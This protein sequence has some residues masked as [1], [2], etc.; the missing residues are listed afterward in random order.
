MRESQIKPFIEVHRFDQCPSSWRELSNS[1][2]DEDWIVVVNGYDDYG[3]AE[4]IAEQIE[5][6]REPQGVLLPDGR[7][8]WICSHA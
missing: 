3:W 1:G 7:P 5:H 6:G 8:A 4:T 2:G